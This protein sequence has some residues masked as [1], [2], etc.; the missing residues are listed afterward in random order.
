MNQESRDRTDAL[1]M[2][3]S[4]HQMFPPSSDE[5]YRAIDEVLPFIRAK[6]RSIPP[7]EDQISIL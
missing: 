5:L 4:R 1:R 6:R 2:V 7:H 3:L